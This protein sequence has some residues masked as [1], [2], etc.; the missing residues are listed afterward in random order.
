MN[1]LKINKIRI[2]GNENYFGEIENGWNDRIWLGF[3]LG[4]II[5]KRIFEEVK[6]NVS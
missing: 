1:K 5:G 3:I 4:D 2:I 6:F